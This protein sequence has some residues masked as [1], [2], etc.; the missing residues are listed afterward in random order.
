MKNF[1]FKTD[2]RRGWKLDYGHFICENLFL[3]GIWQNCEIFNPRKFL[4]IWYSTVR[5]KQPFSTLVLF[6]LIMQ[7]KY[8]SH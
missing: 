1:K 8:Q 4:A 5:N 2:A 3:S 6:M 7:I